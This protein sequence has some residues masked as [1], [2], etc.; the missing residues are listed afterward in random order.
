LTI[1]G[2]SPAQVAQALARDRINVWNGH[3]YGWEPVKRL[4]LLEAGGIV[5]VSLAQYN[6]GEEVAYFLERMAAIAGG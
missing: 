3:N 5:R 1:A 2:K 4:G 6:T